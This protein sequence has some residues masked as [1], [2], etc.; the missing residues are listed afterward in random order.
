[1]KK[2]LVWLTV[3]IAAVMLAAFNKPLKE[4]IAPEKPVSKNI[5]LAVY[6]SDNYKA[7]IYANASAS[8]Q[9][10]IVSVRNGERKLVWQK[11]YDAR[12]LNQYP[13]LAN[14]LAEKVVVN[15]VVDSKDKLEVIY[16]LTYT[17]NGNHL[18][19]QDGTIINKGQK[20]GRLFI[21]I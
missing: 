12:L 17:D 2:Q 16:T 11:N 14:A 19:L 5:S 8:L 1:M 6:S 13:S 10:S 7:S 18:Q 3:V 21:N 20:D 15:N 9:V 4:I